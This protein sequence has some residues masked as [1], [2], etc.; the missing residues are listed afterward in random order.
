MMSK[1]NS[2]GP[3]LLSNDSSARL[4]YMSVDSAGLNTDLLN[5]KVRFA[6]RDP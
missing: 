2:Y 6:I 1:I 3:E 5:N 4:Q